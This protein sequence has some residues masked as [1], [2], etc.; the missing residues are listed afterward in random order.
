MAERV[1]PPTRVEPFFE[2]TP[3]IDVS[4]FRIT[5]RW[6]NYLDSLGQNVNEADNDLEFEISGLETEIR[7]VQSFLPGLQDEINE[8]SGIETE[9]QRTKSQLPSINNRIDELEDTG[10]IFGQLVAKIN[11]LESKIKELEALL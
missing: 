4:S 2:P 8:I 5:V 10:F 6:Q 3:G 7:Q 11:K 9:L 1:F